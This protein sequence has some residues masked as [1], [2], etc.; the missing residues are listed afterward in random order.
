MRSDDRAGRMLRL[1]EYLNAQERPVPVS[2]LAELAGREFGVSEVTLRSD[3]AA[4]CALAPVRKLSRGL[5]EAARDGASSSLL[6][7]TLFAT[8]L[9]LRS[10][11]K[12]A[13]AGA[14]VR[15]LEGRQGLRVLLL[16]AGST[17]YYVADLLAERAGLDLIVWTPS[18]AAASRL[19]GSRGIS[20]RLLGGEYQ[21]DYAV[22]FGD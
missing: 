11:A 10:E 16:D 2:E 14:A 6:S 7:G 8:R 18:V 15:A 20:V 3:L 22:V 13:I 9:R 12:I 4:L 5:Y 19:A 1:L 17:T 21:A